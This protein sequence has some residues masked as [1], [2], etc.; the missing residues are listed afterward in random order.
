[1][2]IVVCVKSVPTQ[3]TKVA[4]AEGHDRVSYEAGP[5]LINESDEYALEEAMALKNQYGGEV[6][7]ITVGPLKTQQVLYVG[8]AKGAD[9]A[10]RIDADFANGE[11]TSKA[12]A[13]ALSNME[14]D[15]IL[16]GVESS[17]AMAAQ[18]GV[19]LAERLGIP[20]AYAVT[21][22]E[23][24]EKEGTLRIAKEMGGGVEQ[25]LEMSLPA[26]MC[27]Q[28]GIVPVNYTSL[29]KLLQA[30][31]KPV[32][33]LTLTDLNIKDV[34]TREKQVIL[35][36]ISLAK[37]TRRAEMLAGATSEVASV[38]VQKIKGAL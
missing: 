15:L 9:K 4:V 33:C 8:L 24:G 23:K 3:V 6:T 38:V 21:K 27:I 7:V 19:S 31:S 1:M 36:D 30:R 25:V 10:I 20:F 34:G 32:R 29:R 22:V 2:K 28:V 5:F 12:L 18:V 16:T 17:D 26:L 35:V 13:A 37:R 14:Y 11:S